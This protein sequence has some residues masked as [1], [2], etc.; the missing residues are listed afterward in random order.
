MDTFSH[1]L[2]IRLF[3]NKWYTSCISYELLYYCIKLLLIIGRLVLNEQVLKHV[4]S[5]PPSAVYIRQ[6]T[7]SS[8]VQVIGL[9][10]IRRQAITWTNAALLS[11]GLMGKKF[12]EIGIGILSFSFKK[13]HL[14]RSSAKTAA[15]LSRERWVKQESISISSSAFRDP[16]IRSMCWSRSKQLHCHH[17]CGLYRD[18]LLWWKIASRSRHFSGIMPQRSHVWHRGYSDKY[19]WS[20]IKVCIRRTRRIAYLPDVIAQSLPQCDGILSRK[21]AVFRR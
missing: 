9:S 2:L 20:W 6:W 3:V 14:K 10:P 4:N 7:A 18:V 5:S 1:W 19:M 16:R 13:V 21:W 12:S 8:S 15:I 17:W 11:I